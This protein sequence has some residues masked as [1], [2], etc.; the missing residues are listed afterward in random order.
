MLGFFCFD[1]DDFVV[2]LPGRAIRWSPLTIAFAMWELK[3]GGHTAYDMLRRVL[4]LPGKSSLQRRI[5]K[6]PFGPGYHPMVWEKTRELYEQQGC[7]KLAN[8]R[9]PVVGLY[10]A[11]VR[12]IMIIE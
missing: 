3:R 6:Y 10:D 5:N 9:I 11:M 7:A 2:R 1:I 8:G 4:F 12:Q